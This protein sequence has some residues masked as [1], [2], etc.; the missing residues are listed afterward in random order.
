MN[1][2]FKITYKTTE[3]E[4]FELTIP[5]AFDFDSSI[6][7]NV[8]RINTAAQN[9]LSANAIETG[10]GDLDSIDSIIY[11]KNDVTTYDVSDL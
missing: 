4:L 10:C 6:P 2:S 5:N 8:T 11:C 7:E 3:S 9:I 1:P